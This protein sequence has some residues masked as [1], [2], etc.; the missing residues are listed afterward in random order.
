MRDL[1][2]YFG[3]KR[4]AAQQALDRMKATYG[5]KDGEHVFYGKVAKAKR[6][7]RRPTRRQR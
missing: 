6:R 1:D 4:G 7:E 2:R 3:G 5:V